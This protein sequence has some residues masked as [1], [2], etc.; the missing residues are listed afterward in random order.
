MTDQLKSDLQSI[1]HATKKLEFCSRGHSSSAR[2]RYCRLLDRPLGERRNAK[3]LMRQV[4]LFLLWTVRIR[5]FVRLFPYISK[6][7]LLIATKCLY[8]VGSHSQI[9]QNSGLDDPKMGAGIKTPNN[10]RFR[11]C[12]N[13]RVLIFQMHYSDNQHRQTIGYLKRQLNLCLSPMKVCI[14]IQCKL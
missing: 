11:V 2:L 6:T 3:N 7:S 10:F 13:R 14:N 5:M 1:L 8:N 4:P 12:K 9:A